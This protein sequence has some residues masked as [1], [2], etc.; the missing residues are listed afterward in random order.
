MEEINN[1]IENLK[2]LFSYKE[3]KLYW[4]DKARLKGKLAGYINKD[5]YIEVNVNR[6]K[7]LAHRIIFAI[8][9]DYLPDLI[10]HIDRNPKNNNVNNL[11]AASKALN[12]INTGIPKNNTSGIKGVSWHKKA[13]KWTAQIKIKGKKVHLGIFSSIIDAEKARKNAEKE[14]FI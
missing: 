12:A 13:R 8:H 2:T 14:A 9:H 5:G 4:S 11:R 7:Y 10:D 6:K 1:E 3:G